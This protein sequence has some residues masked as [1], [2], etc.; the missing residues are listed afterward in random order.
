MKAPIKWNAGGSREV[1]AIARPKWREIRQGLSLAVWGNLF[2]LGPGL[3]GLLALG[4]LE[5]WAQ[6]Y[7]PWDN[8]DIRVLAMT[9]AGVGLSLG[10]ALVLV[11]Q[12]RCLIYAPQEHGAKELQFATLLSCLVLP[13]CLSTAQLVGGMETYTALK[14][15][16]WALLEL[17]YLSAALLIQIFA[18]LLALLN[19][20]LFS[21]FVRAIARVA[22]DAWGARAALVYFWYVAFLAGGTLGVYLEGR[23]TL[24]V[25]MMPYLALAWLL[26]LIGHVVLL[27]GVSQ[28]IARMLRQDDSRMLT[29]RPKA[30]EKGQIALQVATYFPRMP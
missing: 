13:V 23:R 26:G 3:G 28:R 11:G 25:D 8:E 14:R 12:W 24:Q 5:R 20:L 22:R 27:R 2:L 30:R 19:L 29:S 10:Y 1:N 17:D 16:P 15:G 21:G 18:L 4:P 9:L 6:V 7:L